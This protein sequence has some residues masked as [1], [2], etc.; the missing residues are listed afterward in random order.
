MHANACAL[1]TSPISFHHFGGGGQ[2]GEV[3]T[4]YDVTQ[5]SSVS[6][7][8]CLVCVCVFLCVCVCVCVC[9]S[10]NAARARKDDQN[11]H[12]Q[13]RQTLQHCVSTCW[14]PKLQECSSGALVEGAQPSPRVSM[15]SLTPSR[16]PGAVCRLKLKPEDG[17]ASRR[18]WMSCQPPLSCPAD[19]DGWIA[20]VTRTSARG[21]KYAF[22]GDGVA[23]LGCSV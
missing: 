4:S 18:G 11:V 12:H 20:G 19:T 2:R 17:R 14:G 6:A 9:V 15:P 21:S 8:E 13:R 16:R 10:S 7:M 22:S 1:F 5:C 3:D 23:G